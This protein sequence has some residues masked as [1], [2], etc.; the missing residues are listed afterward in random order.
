MVSCSTFSWL[1]TVIFILLLEAKFLNINNED[2][3]KGGFLLRIK[4]K[5]KAKRFYHSAFNW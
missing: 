2:G 1:Q 4:Y 5:K 3:K